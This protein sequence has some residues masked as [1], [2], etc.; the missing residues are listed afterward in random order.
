[1]KTALPNIIVT[2]NNMTKIPGKYLQSHQEKN[3]EETK[4]IKE[5]DIPKIKTK[6]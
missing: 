2:K 4:Q 6:F 1:M 3:Y 5:E